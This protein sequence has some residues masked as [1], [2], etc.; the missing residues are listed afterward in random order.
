MGNFK[1]EVEA[2]GGHGCQREARDG[3]TVL[4]CGRMDCPDCIARVFVAELKRKGNS[5]VSARLVHWPGQTS[6]VVDDLLTGVRT[7]SF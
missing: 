6:Q 4:G 3:Q 5:M 7:G 1:I 2:V